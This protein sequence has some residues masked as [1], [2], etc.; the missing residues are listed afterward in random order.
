M[1][2]EDEFAW[3]ALESVMKRAEPK[4]K[5]A[6]E[7]RGV[8]SPSDLPKHEAHQIF[9]E[10]LLGTTAETN[11][12]ASVDALRHGMAAFDHDRFF[13]AFKRIQKQCEERSDAFMPASGIDAAIVL[14]GMGLYVVPF[15][16]KRPRI[17]GEPSNDIDTVI[18]QFSAWKSAYVGYSPCDAPF[19]LLTTDCIRTAVEQIKVRPELAEA[20]ELLSRDGGTW[21]AISQ[22]MFQHGIVL[23]ARRPADTFTTVFLNNSSPTQGSVSLYAGWKVGD[24]REGSPN[25]GFL[26]VPQQFLSAIINDPKIGMWIW[27][28]VGATSYIN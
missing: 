11:P 7:A 1:S 13:P 25:D 4:L 26:P 5:A 6:L 10:I 3:A 8:T 15:D 2:T 12:G 23:F 27:N 22:A 20:K 9:T 21:P 18:E 17:L 28:P 24:S 14:A 19:Y 16:R